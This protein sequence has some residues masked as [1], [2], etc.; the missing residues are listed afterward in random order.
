MNESWF[1]VIEK[2]EQGGINRVYR[3]T[4]CLNN[5]LISTDPDGEFIQFVVAAIVGGGINLYNNWGKV[6]NLRDGLVYFGNG[7]V[8]GIGTLFSGPGGAALTGTLNLTYDIVIGETAN[9]NSLED[10][11]A[12]GADLIL[13]ATMITPAGSIGKAINTMVSGRW[14]LKVIN[15]AG[16]TVKIGPGPGKRIHESAQGSDG[17]C[18]L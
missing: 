4:Y 14:S 10:A 5:P 9:I 11:V 6:D 2:L 17:S 8:G 13:D 16:E 15:S 7:A 18:C 1:L 3:Y 12:Y